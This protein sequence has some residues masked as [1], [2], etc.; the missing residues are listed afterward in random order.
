MTNA[1]IN[2]YT[3]PRVATITSTDPAGMLFRLSSMSARFRG[4]TLHLDS[5]EPFDT[6]V[7]RLNAFQPAGLITFASMANALA[8]AQQQ[9]TLR[10]SPRTV[11]SSGE[12]LTQSGRRAFEDVWGADVLNLYGCTEAGQLAVECGEHRGMHLLDD[13]VIVENV[14]EENRPVPPGE[15]GAKL[16]ITTLFRRTQPLIR[17]EVS[18]SV[19][20]ATAPCTCRLSY[21]LIDDI[22]GR[23]WDVLYFDRP[24]GGKVPVHPLV[25]NNVMEPVPA[26]WQVIHEPA[27]VRVLVSN[28]RGALDERQ[29]TDELS[30]AIRAQ[31]AAAPAIR[32]E[33]VSEIPHGSG[34]K[35]PLIWST[36]GRPA[37]TG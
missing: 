14:D 9:G 6:I 19:R 35:A 15:Y 17:Y 30:R 3:W 2:W 10:I 36:V 34:G 33:R 37:T 27:G 8:E 22:Q 7:Q 32:V 24:Q 13:L 5:R 21:P 26:A 28:V 20:F 23:V 12:V 25:I 1:G 18:D 11:V 16:L 29:L 4:R 31:G